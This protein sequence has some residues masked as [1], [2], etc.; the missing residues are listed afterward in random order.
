MKRAPWE[1]PITEREFQRIVLQLAT[2][3]GWHHWHDND[4]RG[5][6]AGFLDLVLVRERVIWVELKT[7]KGRVRPEQAEW[8]ERLRD[9]G[10]HVYVWRPSD[11]EEI[12]VTLARPK[13]IQ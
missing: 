1:G 2:L 9:A 13:S 7:E 3:R 4:S 11:W 6:A 10:Q 8:I 12:S 5:N